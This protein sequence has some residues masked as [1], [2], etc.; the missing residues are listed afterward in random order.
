M[1]NT[2]NTTASPMDINIPVE[3]QGVSVLGTE[4]LL[5]IAESEANVASDSEQLPQILLDGLSSHITREFQINKDA[6]RN[7]LTEHSIITSLRQ[8]NGEY[9]PKDLTRILQEGG[10]KIFMK[11]TSTKCRAAA[12]WIKDILIAENVKSWSLAPTPSPDIPP[13]IKEMIKESMAQEFEELTAPPAPPQAGPAE[14]TMPSQ[15]PMAGPPAPPQEAPAPE[16]QA[17]PAPGAKTQEAQ[18]TI[19]EMNQTRRDIVEAVYEEIQKEAKSEMIVMERQIDDQLVE[20]D[21]YKVLYDFID[22]FVVFPTAFMKGPII[23]KKKKIAWNNGLPETKIEYVFMNK[24][25]SPFDIYPAPEATSL[26]EGSLCEHLRLSRSEVYNLLGLP[27][28]NDEKIRQALEEVAVGTPPSFLDSGIESEKADAESR[29]NDFEANRNVI[30]GVH[31]FGSVQGKDLI[32]WGMNSDQIVFG[33]PLA[34]YQVEAILVGNIVVKCVM[35]LDPLLR[36]PYY[37]ASFQ[38]KPGSLWGTSLPELM[39]DNQRMCN[40]TAR[41]LSNNMALASGPQVEIYIDRLAD[42]GDISEIY[43]FKIW[44]LTS[45]PTGAQGRAV[46]FFQ[47]Q[48]NAAELLKV[49]QEFEMKAD[50]ATGIPRYAYGNENVKGAAE[51]ASGLAMLLEA[52]SKGI[53]DAIRNIDLGVIVP[54]IEYQFYWN[55]ISNSIEF[56]GDVHV[57]ALGSSNLTVKGSEQMKRNEF[58]SITSNPIDQEIMGVEGRATLLREMAKDLGFVEDIIP[59]RLDIAKRKKSEEEG[60]AKAQESAMAMEEHK[61]KLNN[62]AAETQ[63]SGQERMSQLTQEVKIVAEQGRMARHAKDSELKAAEIASFQEENTFKSMAAGQKTAADNAT[64]KEIANREIAL[65]L[66]TGSGI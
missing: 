56:S 17:P 42:A 6:K 25:V 48:S 60:A 23:Q 63:I 52:A 7:S 37:C 28:Y 5:D 18:E 24:R 64:K 61:A 38:K 58:L 40:A 26:Q 32:D 65:A 66:A 22:D 30:H 54:R 14:P 51:S 3:S 45:D 1:L 39:E 57:M 46:N 53:K 27:G 16:P 59:T 20:G 2:N 50:D 35:N 4:D 62:L 33:D 9:S 31:Y 43:P 34:E 36:R 10:S 12:S 11:L 13:E 29:G 21:Y 15:N 19:R 55:V 8:Y 41:A 49:F 47:P 44:Q